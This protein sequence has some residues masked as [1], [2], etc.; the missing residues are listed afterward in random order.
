MVIPRK[1]S[2]LKVHLYS[3]PM[4]ASKVIHHVH[5][6]MTGSIET[7]LHGHI[8][9]YAALCGPHRELIIRHDLPT[10]AQLSWM[11]LS[12]DEEKTIITKY[13]VLVEGAESTQQVSLQDANASSIEV[14]GL[15]PFTLYTYRISARSRLGTG[16]VATIS[17]TTP[18]GG[19]TQCIHV[20]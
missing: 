5:G 19:E 14:S 2:F 17:S 16:P 7:V 4:H 9:T 13:T 8:N 6:S 10:T 11:P 3:F 20:H 1:L 18:E 12:G 15:K